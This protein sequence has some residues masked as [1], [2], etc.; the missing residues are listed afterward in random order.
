MLAMKIFSGTS[1]PVLAQ[2]ICNYLD[3][4]LGEVELSEFPN[5]ETF[6]QIRESIRGCDVFVI[7]STHRPANHYTMEM[8]IMID[9]IRRASASRIT[10]VL[11]YF[12]YARQ[13]RKDKPRVP[14]TSK[15]I[16]N[17]LVSAGVNRILTMDL[18]TPQI[19]G[20][21][22]IPTDH[23]FAAPI[24]IDYMKAHDCRNMAVCSPDIG[25]M[26]MA[27]AYADALGCSLA[28]IAKRRSDTLHVEAIDVIGE[29]AGKDIL[30]VD[31][32][33]ET[34]ETLTVAAKLLK[35]KG[36]LSIKAAVS[37]GILTEIGQE[38]LKNSAIDLLI[39][40]NST[41][42][43]F[44]EKLPIVKL[45]ICGLFGEA[46]RRIHEGRSVTSLFGI[47]GF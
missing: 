45:D 34:A 16:A 43:E 31:D 47:R 22:D 9:A 35:E 4:P 8:L 42:M 41:P 44:G 19:V 37:H 25:G 6:I 11:P 1:N 14:I 39:T 12:G 24:I 13:D 18:H 29:V 23:L 2:G 5:G 28:L 15:L 21:F 17:L 40:T 33:T 26:K 38:K 3:I 46:I 7:Q 32:I 27:T 30:L 10:A 20:F 36:A